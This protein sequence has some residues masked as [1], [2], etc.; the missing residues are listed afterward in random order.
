MQ[1]VKFNVDETGKIISYTTEIGGADT[2]FPFSNVQQICGFLGVASDSASYTNAKPSL[3]SGIDTN[4]FAVNSDGSITA[5]MDCKIVVTYF[6]YGAVT[7]QGGQLQRKVRVLLNGTVACPE[8]SVSGSTNFVVG[9]NE[10]EISTGDILTLQ[11]LINSSSTYYHTPC[12]M[13]I[14][15]AE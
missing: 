14:G 5:K 11:C 1:G 10:L 6:T 4:Y 15:L 3:Y 8:K 9:T 7:G 13:F 12:G 2:E